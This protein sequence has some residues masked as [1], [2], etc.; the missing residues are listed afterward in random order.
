MAE[1]RRSQ[2]P[3]LASGLNPPTRPGSRGVRSRV[4]SQGKSRSAPPILPRRSTM[5]GSEREQKALTLQQLQAAQASALNQA[6][7]GAAAAVLDEGAAE[8]LRRAAEAADAAEL[9]AAAQMEAERS[10]FVRGGG[11]NRTPIRGIELIQ[12]PPPQ[13]GTTPERPHSAVSPLHNSQGRRASASVVPENTR[14][15][16]PPTPSRVP[17]VQQPG[18]STGA[19]PKRPILP[20]FPALNVGLPPLVPV[21]EPFRTIISQSAGANTPGLVCN[22]F[23]IG[24]T[25]PP[26]GALSGRPTPTRFLDRGIRTPFGLDDTQDWDATI[27]NWVGT[28]RYQ[29]DYRDRCYYQD[30]NNYWYLDRYK[31]RDRNR[32]TD[33]ELTMSTVNNKG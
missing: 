2:N 23:E 12:P 9:A 6:A 27:Y 4:G 15:P 13:G 29:G 26:P 20:P 25:S 16:P 22:R 10:A 8:A 33:S 3:D 31:D 1:G 5:S 30:S 19:L 14:S 28:Y 32:L 24:E 18:S 17:F 7:E 11:V 21:E